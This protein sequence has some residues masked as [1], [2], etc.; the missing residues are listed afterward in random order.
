MQGDIVDRKRR[1]K[2]IFALLFLAPAKKVTWL[3]GC[4]PPVLFFI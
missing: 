3:A 1:V 2:T 4:N